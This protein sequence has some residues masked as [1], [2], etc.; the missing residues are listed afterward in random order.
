MRTTHAIL[1]VMFV[2]RCCSF[3]NGECIKT[4]LAQVESWIM[5]HGT[6]WT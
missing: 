4:G 2:R 5:E 3:S 6:F 1:T